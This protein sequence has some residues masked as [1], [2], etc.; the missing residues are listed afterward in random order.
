MSEARPL[1]GG[2]GE[3]EGPAHSPGPYMSVRDLP[4]VLSDEGWPCN[5]CCCCADQGL[6]ALPAFPGTCCSSGCNDAAGASGSA[7]DSEATGMGATELW[8]LGAAPMAT[9]TEENCREMTVT[10]IPRL[11][12]TRSSDKRPGGILSSS[13]PCADRV[14]AMRLTTHMVMVQLLVVMIKFVDCS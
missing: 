9:R 4:G 10:K 3:K 2:L 6:G 8:T 1:A 11:K 12:A 13:S 5:P 7:A 14:I